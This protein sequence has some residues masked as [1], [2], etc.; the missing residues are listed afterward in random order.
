M[1]PNSPALQNLIRAF[2]GFSAYIYAIPADLLDPLLSLSRCSNEVRVELPDNLILVHEF[3]HHYSLQAAKEMTVDGMF[4][5]LDP[6][7]RSS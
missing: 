3:G 1:H 4:I 6:L 2:R 5:I 7:K